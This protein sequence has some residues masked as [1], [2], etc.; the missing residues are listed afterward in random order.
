MSACL[1]TLYQLC[2]G[3]HRRF[4]HKK[5]EEECNLSAIWKSPYKEIKFDFAYC[6][7]MANY[8]LRGAAGAW[9]Q[10]TDGVPPWRPFLYYQNFHGVST[11]RLSQDNRGAH[12]QFELRLPPIIDASWSLTRGLTTCLSAPSTFQRPTLWNFEEC[13]PPCVFAVTLH[14]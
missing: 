14:E 4:F 10:T 6:N 2:L 1:V 11:Y 9:N 7:E 13:L 8:G 5:V 3:F 12:W